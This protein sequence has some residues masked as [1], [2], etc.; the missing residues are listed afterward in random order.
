MIYARVH[1]MACMWRSEDNLV[2]VGSLENMYL[3]EGSASLKSSV[4]LLYANNDGRSLHCQT[5]FLELIGSN[6][7]QVIKDR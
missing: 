2:G 6:G 1:A 3:L 7:I 4:S 5:R